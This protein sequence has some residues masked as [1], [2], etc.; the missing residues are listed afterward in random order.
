MEVLLANVL[1]GLLVVCRGPQAFTRPDAL[2]DAM[3][4]G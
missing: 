1:V 3:F 2:V 4:E